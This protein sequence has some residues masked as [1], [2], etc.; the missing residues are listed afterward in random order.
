MLLA[1][2][3]SVAH[4]L[5][6]ISFGRPEIAWLSRLAAAIGLLTLFTGEAVARQTT[7][8]PPAGPQIAQYVD[9][10]RFQRQ[11]AGA[12][13][14]LLEEVTRVTSLRADPSPEF[15]ERFDD[16][17]LF[18]YPVLYVNFADRGDWELDASEK[19]ALRDY[20][21]RGGFIFLDA[22]INAAFLR[23]DP[24]YGQT[25]NFPDWQVTPVVEEL[26]A[27]LFPAESFEPLER[28]HP[29]FSAFYRGLP[30]TSSLPETVREFVQNEKWPQG[31]LSMLGLK[32]DGRLA[33]LATPIL[34]MGWEKN[35]YGQWTNQIAFRVRESSEGLSERLSQAAYDGERFEIRREDGRT[36]I[37][38]CQPSPMPAWVQEPDGEWRVFRYYQNREISDYAHQ[39]FTRVGVN[40]FTY[41]LSG[42]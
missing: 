23:D 10:D 6:L 30:D 34:A 40:I 28:S 13:P 38:Y 37:V 26:F 8:M 21:E 22:G 32:V 29:L 5:R 24:R 36:D 42:Y 2:S 41:V 4:A 31:T 27:E 7:P 19:Q 16:P 18:R 9:G 25:H 11:Y 3:P 33:V 17:A 39:F 12:L 1:Q 14:S 35:E 20:L 15:I